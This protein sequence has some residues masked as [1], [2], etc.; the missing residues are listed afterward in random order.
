M[1]LS[2]SILREHA[3]HLFKVRQGNTR[4]QNVMLAEVNVPTHS[5]LLVI[6]RISACGLF[7]RNA[8]LLT[9]SHILGI[10]NTVASI[11]IQ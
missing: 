10:K 7:S 8:G 6:T 9:N 5:P 4:P 11:L 2:S 3:L 1:R